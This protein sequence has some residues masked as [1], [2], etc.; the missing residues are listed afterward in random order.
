MWDKPTQRRLAAVLAADIAGY[1]RLM[2]QDTDATVA[3]WH[4]AR[5]NVIDPQITAH[6]GRI[7]KHTG[8]GFLAEFP[9]VQD[10]VKCAVAM[11]ERLAG[12]AL[13]FRMGVNLGDIIDDGEDIYGEG[14]NVAARLEG[15]AERG[16]ICV[17]GDVFNQVR[18]RI[19]TKFDDKGEQEVKH[20][21]APIRVYALRLEAATISHLDSTAVTDKP[22]I[23]VLPFDNLSGDPE[24]AYF[25]DGMAEEIITALSHYRWFF[26]IARNSSFTY[27]GRAV[28]ARQVGQEL[29]VR[30]LLEGSVRKA[31]NRIR[32]TAQ[33]IDARTGGKDVRSGFRE[34]PPYDGGGI[35]R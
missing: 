27:K 13:D 30:Y 1:T 26:V 11:Q 24:Q 20:V 17:S 33:L 23:A 5:A 19:D 22:S 35:R 3:A 31:G 15:L 14:V 16:G 9:T 34:V 10:A 12:S 4:N 28:D 18:N 25:A 6:A 8:D 29:G 32:V 21:S 7:V 2:E